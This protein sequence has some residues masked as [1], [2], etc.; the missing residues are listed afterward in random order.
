VK[1]KTN[2]S[3]ILKNE[4]NMRQVQEL[5]DSDYHHTAETIGEQVRILD[6]RCQVAS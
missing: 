1:W 3:A 4:E 5:V 6:D 2:A